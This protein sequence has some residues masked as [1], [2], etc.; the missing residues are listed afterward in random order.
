M[1]EGAGEHLAKVVPGVP[2]AGIRDNLE[3]RKSRVYGRD[4]LRG[5]GPSRKFRPAICR[6]GCTSVRQCPM[7]LLRLSVAKKLDSLASSG[8]PVCQ[9]QGT[10]GMLV[11][12]FAVLHRLSI[13]PLV[14]SSCFLLM[15]HP[16]P[17]SA[18]DSSE[19][20]GIWVGQY[21]CGQGVSG[22]SLD[23]EGSERSLSAVFHFYPL[24]ENPRAAEGSF[25]MHG[26][27]DPVIGQLALDPVRWIQ[28]PD[29]YTMVGLSALISPDGETLSGR[30]TDPNCG[31][32]ELT[33]WNESM[34]PPGPQARQRPGTDETCEHLLDWM[35]M[36][37]AA[38]PDL[39]LR[40]T[41]STILYPIIA[42]AYRA[43]Y[44]APYFGSP[45][46]EL[47]QQQRRGLLQNVLRRCERDRNYRELVANNA[48]TLFFRPFALDRGSFSQQELV[49]M[50]EGKD[51]VIVWRDR[52]LA[53]I[54][55][56][57]RTIEGF[58]MLG[59]YIT[60]GEADLSILWPSEQREFVEQLTAARA[61]MAR[62]LLSDLDAEVRSLEVSMDGAQRAMDIVAQSDRILAAIP[63]E[64]ASASGTAAAARLAEILSELFDEMRETLNAL[65]QD[66]AGLEQGRA[67]YASFRQDFR[68]FEGHPAHESFNAEVR[69]WITSVVERL[70]AQ[71]PRSDETEVD[72][73][74]LDEHTSAAIARLDVRDS[75]QNMLLRLYNPGPFQFNDTSYIFIG[76][77][78]YYFV[79]ECGFP[80]NV[81]NRF[82]LER[83]I[84]G[85][86]IR[87]ALGNDYPNPNPGD[88]VINRVNGLQLLAQGREVGRAIGCSAVGEGVTNAILNAV[89]SNREAAEGG[90]PSFVEGCTQQFSRSQCSC[91]AGI[92]QIVIPNIH[93]TSYDRMV[94]HR[95]IQG[96]P[97]LVVRIMTECGIVNY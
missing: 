15:A 53:A 65:A 49:R 68:P 44:F 90:R 97:L 24:P 33:R 17:A 14:L 91:L 74:D 7:R 36:V 89:K 32:L 80:R 54:D 93:Q 31:A 27:F 37:P 22:F 13:V 59:A 57:P 8:E 43:E 67:L 55:G 82:E 64:T 28:R 34:P 95:I 75:Y 66:A 63:S 12:I 81:S 21:Q 87:A 46:P 71:R 4:G 20:E 50:L 60:Q 25:S 11:V 88:M 73:P 83:F 30:I 70:E 3:G 1:H 19:I 29:L 76:G 2:G 56:I 85:V 72:T 26:G 69:A 77:V 52:V 45:F 92:G 48:S 47:N 39:D 38:Y 62:S 35:G 79:Q 6:K 5:L 61:D 10:W 84:Q 94:I 51:A 58:E 40:R 9:R 86:E 23:I 41:S 16:T 18:Q 96:N 42:N 78:A